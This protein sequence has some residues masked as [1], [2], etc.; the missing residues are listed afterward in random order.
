MLPASPLPALR[1]GSL[2]DGSLS[3][4]AH[5]AT[6]AHEMLQCK[7]GRDRDHQEVPLSAAVEA[8]VLGREEQV[9]A[10]GLLVIL[11]T[12]PAPRL[13]V[14]MLCCARLRSATLCDAKLC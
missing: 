7:H 2:R 8:V 14:A 4:H 10:E 9:F 11:V 5:R 1:S 3:L 6:S 12:A 13:G